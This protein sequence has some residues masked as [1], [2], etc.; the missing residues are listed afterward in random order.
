[1]DSNILLAVVLTRALIMSELDYCN[2]A[3]CG[4]TLEDM[5]ETLICPEGST[6]PSDGE[7]WFTVP[8][9]AQFRVQVVTYKARHLHR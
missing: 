3:E 8:F 4:A 6:F 9:C 1:M 5:A 7:Q 2:M